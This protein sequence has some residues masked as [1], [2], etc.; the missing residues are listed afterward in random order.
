MAEDFV[1][2]HYNKTYDTERAN[3]Q[4]HYHP[5]AMLTFESENHVGAQAISAKLNSLPFQQVR[6]TVLTVRV[7]P[8][9]TSGFV[10]ALVTGQFEAL[11]LDKPFG[12][13]QVFQLAVPQSGRAEDFLVCND[14]FMLAFN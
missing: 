12:Y 14:L 13:S 4:K 8:S 7:Q 5:E 11:G 1:N 6:H 3:I 10:I 9:V 2:N